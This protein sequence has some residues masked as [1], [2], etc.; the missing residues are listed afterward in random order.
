MFNT[1][2]MHTVARVGRRLAEAGREARA[3]S[4]TVAGAAADQVTEVIGAAVGEVVRAAVIGAV[5]AVR[6]AADAPRTPAIPGHDPW[7]DE[8]AGHDRDGAAA[9]PTRRRRGPGGPRRRGRSD[10]R[11][12]WRPARRRRCRAAGWWPPAW[13]DWPPSPGSRLAPPIRPPVEASDLTSHQQT[14]PP[15]PRARSAGRGSG[16][17]APVSARGGGQPGHAAGGRWRRRMSD[18]ELE[19]NSNRRNVMSDS[20]GTLRPRRPQ[21][22][23]SIERLDAM[24]EDLS[25]A[26]PGAVG[27]SVREVLGAAIKDAVKAAVAEALAEVRGTVAVPPPVSARPAHRR[28]RVAGRR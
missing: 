2:L 5:A 19:T 15:Y 7:G 21:L 10:R 8:D 20:N 13:A 27:E 1:N 23:D 25:S 26:I 17:L 24:I 16:L 9:P 4:T 22:A 11:C 28:R 14:T 6:G 3:A 12:R 18:D